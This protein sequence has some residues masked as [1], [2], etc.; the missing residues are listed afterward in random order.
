MVEKHLTPELIL[1]GSK[2][3]Q[4]LDDAGVAPDS[5]LW[6]YSS[7]ASAWKL[8]ISHVKVGIEGPR[9]V[10]RAVQ[11]A[12]HRLRNEVTH[13]DL[14]DVTVAKSN[15]PMIA[16]LSKAVSTGP[17]ISGIRLARNVVDGTL[18]EDAY[19]YRLKG[20]A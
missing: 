5:A 18:I 9:D 7:D 14:D 11:K 10:Y 4:G 2:L 15:A 3:L 1:E 6:L 13:L 19:I 16:L 17:G 8:L 20:A 12:L